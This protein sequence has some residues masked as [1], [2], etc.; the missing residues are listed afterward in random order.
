MSHFSVAVVTNTGSEE[1]VDRLL[2]PYQENNMGDCPEEYLEFI[3]DEDEGIDDETGKR[4]YWENPNA[5]WDWY[6]LGG[7]AS[8]LMKLKSGD[9]T[10]TAKIKDIDLSIDKEEYDK[11]SHNWEVAVEGLYPKDDELYLYNK[12]YY[13]TRFE[14]KEQYATYCATFSTFAIVV[15]NG[16]WIEKGEM[17][18]FGLENSNIESRS[19]YNRALSTILETM[20]DKYITIVDCHI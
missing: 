11:A 6:R 14:S 10:N 5:K 18:W 15:P 13:T 4:G 20:K 19:K 17:G 2:A 7:R 9:T 8:G 16:D 1:E 3:E 12:D